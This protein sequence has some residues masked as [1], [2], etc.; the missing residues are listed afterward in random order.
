MQVVEVKPYDVP[1]TAAH[2]HHYWASQFLVR[3][4]PENN[5]SPHHP[6]AYHERYAFSSCASVRSRVRVQVNEELVVTLT[7]EGVYLFK[8]TPHLPMGMVMAVQVGAP[9]N[10]DAIKAIKL[11]NKTAERM[12]P[13]LAAIVP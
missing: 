12:T 11:N 9:T 6:R 13:V 7:T 3:E 4:V 2:M 10:L 8:C 1:L 5:Q